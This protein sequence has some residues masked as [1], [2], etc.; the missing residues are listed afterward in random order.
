MH[1]S[2]TQLTR[3]STEGNVVNA[4]DDL[5]PTKLLLAAIDQAG[6][7]SPLDASRMSGEDDTFGLAVVSSTGKVRV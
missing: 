6:I 5:N 1:L 4:L 3:H 7:S 2:S